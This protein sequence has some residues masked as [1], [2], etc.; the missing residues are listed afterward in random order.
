MKV[1]GRS[2]KDADMTAPARGAAPQACA[3]REI[4]D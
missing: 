1:I 2:G 3:N 4:S